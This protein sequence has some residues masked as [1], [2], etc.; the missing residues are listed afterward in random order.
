MTKIKILSF[1]VLLILIPFD[2]FSQ[3]V[4]F[5]RFNSR[6]GL[7]SSE[8]Y[9]II[10]D[11]F[12]YIWFSTDKGISRYNGYEFEN[13]DETDGLPQYVVFD[14][15]KDNKGAIWCSTLTGELFTIKGALPVFT[16]YKYNDLILKNIK[17]HIVKSLYISDDEDVLISLKSSD[18]FLM[19]D[20]NGSCLS[21]PIVYSDLSFNVR[22]GKGS[23][24][25]IS[26]DK[27]ESFCY[28]TLNHLH[29]K[30][31]SRLNAQTTKSTTFNP[32]SRFAFTESFIFQ[33]SNVSVYL[34]LDSIWINRNGRIIKIKNKSTMIAA[35]KFDENHFWVG[36]NNG[37]VYIYDLKG[38]IVNHFL[39]TESVSQLFKDSENNLWVSTLNNGVF[40]IN[41]AKLQ[42]I[43]VGDKASLRI[44]SLEVVADKLYIGTYD[45]DIYKLKYSTQIE[46]HYTSITR[47]E[48]VIYKSEL[49][50]NTYFVSD[51]FSS[52]RKSTISGNTRFI[53]ENGVKLVYG[54][55]R[56]Y[57]ED[58]KT[59][60][61]DEY[62]LPARTLCAKYVGNKLYLGTAEGLYIFKNGQIKEVPRFKNIRINVIQYENNKIVLG[63]NGNG[64]Y[65]LNRQHEVLRHYTSKNG[66]S[67]NFVS[68]ILIENDHAIWCCTNAGLNRINFRLKVSNPVDQFNLS[69]D[70]IS[71]ELWDL[72]IFNDTLWIGAQSGLACI[73]KKDLELDHLATSNFNLKFLKLLVNEKMTSFLCSSQFSAT[74]NEIE[75]N[76]TGISFRKLPKLKYRYRLVGAD[77]EWKYTFL[78]GI[79]YSSLAPNKYEF[80][81]QA[82]DGYSPWHLNE[83]RY[84]FEILT[85][86]Y[87]TWWFLLGTIALV[88]FLIYLF[89]K[90]RILSYN[91]YIVQEILRL[92]LKRIRKK[93]AFVHFKHLGKD[94]KIESDKIHFI[95][96]DGNYLEIH[97]ED[98]VYLY[99][100]SFENFISSL[101]DS[102]EYLRIH[103]SYL[104][105]IDAIQ[106][107]SKKQLVVLNQEI[108]VGRKYWEVIDTI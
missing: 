13:F 91:R 83:I 16:T 105:R 82:S 55:G 45:G 69:G 53:A 102:I 96:S 43:I 90:Y 31:P 4:S 61:V 20:K 107:K 44:H 18:G 106:E 47:K 100:S 64:V 56:L 9:D 46:K 70:L 87:K 7:P 19:I 48:A 84:K 39:K 49:S 51:N 42:L 99:R 58:L 10:Q 32:N 71:D 93:K 66:L 14:F 72:E 21:K 29:F 104:V 3:N 63:T 97:T 98:K 94:V 22:Y 35:G 76:Y 38:K 17:N 101:P 33:K 65:I 80:I 11:D 15:V 40:L 36:H 103:R 54:L 8:V 60:K 24:K 74:Q 95:K 77:N 37:G 108:P 25:S 67:S 27:K 1:L 6:D 86:F 81:V 88:L 30:S 41:N 89:F 85:P 5:V 12:G 23:F 52:N 2:L 92:I 59:K 78:R 79:K 50:G 57:I 26:D 34:D 73:A 62:P 28:S 75:F 68:N